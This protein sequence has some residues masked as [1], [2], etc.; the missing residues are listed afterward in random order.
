MAPENGGVGPARGVSVA[1]YLVHDS[2]QPDLVE[3]Q[4]PRSG[5]T[6]RIAPKPD[7]AT[8]DI[9]WATME[10]D[11][12][13]GR[14]VLIVH[15][16]PMGQSKLATLTSQNVG[17]W[18]AIAVDGEFIATPLIQEPIRDGRVSIVGFRSVEEAQR[19]ADGLARR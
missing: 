3:R 10:R 19:V 14:P 16:T 2:P 17:K 12:I 9:A 7:I 8:S 4:V 1:F 15:L 6:L 11:E 5:T 13:R 18:M